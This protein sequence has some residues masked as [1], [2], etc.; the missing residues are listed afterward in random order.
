MEKLI[1]AALK[2]LEMQITDFE[3]CY[4]EWIRNE[5]ASNGMHVKEASIS[6]Y[7]LFP[8]VETLY[9]F[10]KCRGPTGCERRCIYREQYIDSYR[11][12]YIRFYGRGSYLRE[13]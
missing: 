9:K 3:S 6:I 10:A 8:R 13:R 5:M 1:V 4:S 11:R 12:R 7:T 2:R